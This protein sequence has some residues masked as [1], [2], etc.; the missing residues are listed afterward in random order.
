MHAPSRGLVYRPVT[1]KNKSESTTTTKTVSTI[2]F[3]ISSDNMNMKN[4]S[5]AGRALFGAMGLPLDDDLPPLVAG[6]L[7]CSAFAWGE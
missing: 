4:A 3:E 7:L 2:N 5:A 1:L 6:G